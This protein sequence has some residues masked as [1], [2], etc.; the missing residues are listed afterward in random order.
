MTARPV[1]DY[2]EARAWLFERTDAAS[3]MDDP[4]ELPLVAQLVCDFF[5]ISPEKLCAD[6]RRDWR[7]ATDYR[8]LGRPVRRTGWR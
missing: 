1:S 6:M 2:G 4:E 7:S 8:P 3:W 5:W